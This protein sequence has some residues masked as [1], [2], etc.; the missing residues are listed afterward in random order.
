MSVFRRPSLISEKAPTTSPPMS[1]N[2]S[3]N[4]S[5]PTTAKGN[6]IT[7]TSPRTARLQTAAHQCECGHP[8]I[9][10]DA[11]ASRYC[12]ATHAGTLTRGCICHHAPTAAQRDVVVAVGTPSV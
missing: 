12:A 10:H 9:A 2:G 4:V 3:G 1:P 11:I 8:E 7:A 5:P 6:T